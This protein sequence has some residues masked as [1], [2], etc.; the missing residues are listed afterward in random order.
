MDTSPYGVRWLAG[1]VQE[2]C[3]DVW[4]P[5]GPQRRGSLV[6][7]PEPLQS[8]DLS[9]HSHEPRRVVRG[10]AWNMGARAGRCA[11]RAGQAPARRSSNLGF[12]VAR[13][14]VQKD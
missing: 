10:G 7:Q 5:D 11:S 13:T 14:L 12:R 2:W 3:A 4:R 8:A 1:G 6:V 9:P